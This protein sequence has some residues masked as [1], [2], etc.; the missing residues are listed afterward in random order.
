VT[1]QSRYSG[2]I[3]ALLPIIILVSLFFFLNDVV[4]GFFA[5]RIGN[6]LLIIG[7][8]LEITGILVIRKILAVNG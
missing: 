5:S 8:S 1:L 7:G 4:T 3:I 6:I 2:T